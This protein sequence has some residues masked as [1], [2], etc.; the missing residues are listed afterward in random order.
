MSLI[1]TLQEAQRNGAFEKATQ[2]QVVDIR[3]V[4]AKLKSLSS[5]AEQMKFLK[6]EYT[7]LYLLISKA[8]GASTQDFQ[9]KLKNLNVRE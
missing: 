6:Y 1:A 8:E 9:E 2:R 4:I 5:E 3:K 7:C